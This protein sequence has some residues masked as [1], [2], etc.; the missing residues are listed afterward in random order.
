MC[1][2]G[3]AFVPCE[4]ELGVDP[5]HF[6]H[7]SVARYLGQNRGCGDGQRPGI[8]LDQRIGGHGQVGQFVAINERG[9]WSDGQGFNCPPHG[10]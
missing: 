7:L 1:L 3:I 5:V 4:A 8:T 6:Y 2:G 10:K 9:G